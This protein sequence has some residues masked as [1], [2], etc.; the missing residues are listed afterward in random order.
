MTFSHDASSIGS[1]SGAPGVTI[2][3][4]AP[5]I[6]TV[7]YILSEKPGIGLVVVKYPL[8]SGAEW[9]APSSCCFLHHIILVRVPSPCGVAFYGTEL[10]DAPTL[11]RTQ[12]THD[13]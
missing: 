5:I 1:W 7:R 11:N 8:A 10:L 2:A 3:A 12:R 9:H 6:I 4:G 13:R